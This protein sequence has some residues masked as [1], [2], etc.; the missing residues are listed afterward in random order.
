MNA[1]GPMNSPNAMAASADL[2]VGTC[3]Q[4]WRDRAAPPDALVIAWDAIAAALNR[5]RLLDG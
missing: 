1:Y 3:G 4:T 2:I 5:V